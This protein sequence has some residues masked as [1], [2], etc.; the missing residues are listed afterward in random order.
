LAIGGFLGLWR[1]RGRS[2]QS[3]NSARNA[4]HEPD[5]RWVAPNGRRL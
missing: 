1:R 3:R 4:S 5:S 2:A